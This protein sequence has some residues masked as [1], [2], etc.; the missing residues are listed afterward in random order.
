MVWAS[1]VAGDR[2]YESDTVFG[3]AFS[4]ER[5]RASCEITK[6]NQPEGG[7]ARG[8]W[9]LRG[10]LSR[11]R[12]GHGLFLL[13]NG[14]AERL[15]PEQEFEVGVEVPCDALL[16]EGEVGEGLRVVAERQGLDHGGVDFG[17]GGFDFC[18][19]LGVAECEDVFFDG[20]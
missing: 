2:E 13:L 20:V 11:G 7:W 15:K 5:F 6:R 19:R 17:V 9:V 10:S 8:S 14:L 4:G 3:R 16:A 18:E 12:R 1:D